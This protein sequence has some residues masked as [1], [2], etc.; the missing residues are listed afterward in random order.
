M[1]ER[2]G[3]RVREGS[4]ERGEGEG[5]GAEPVAGN[6]AREECH[7]PVRR[8]AGRRGGAE[9]EVGQGGRRRRGGGG[10]LGRGGGEEEGLCAGEVGGGGGEGEELGEE[11]ALAWE[12][13]ED[14]LRVE[15]VER[16]AGGGGVA[17][18]RG[19]AAA[20]VLGEEVEALLQR[21]GV[22]DVRGQVGW[23]AGRRR[24]RRTAAAMAIAVAR[25]GLRA[26]REW[27]NPIE[28]R[29]APTNTLIQFGVWTLPQ[30]CNKVA[31][32]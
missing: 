10:A 32:M 26:A 25:H 31:K 7:Q 3:A 17:V 21:A 18:A 9:N 11:E 30:M 16:A 29:E 12:A 15:L 28:Q 8:R 5:V 24:R 13:V 19:D 20:A 6:E 27:V 2:R 4:E 23:V 22:G 1:W 14:H